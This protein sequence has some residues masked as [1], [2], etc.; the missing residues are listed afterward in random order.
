MR[1]RERDV[2]V[3]IIC[4]RIYD[5]LAL[6]AWTQRKERERERES[7]LPTRMAIFIQIAT[8]PNANMLDFH[9]KIQGVNANTVPEGDS[10]EKGQS[11]KYKIG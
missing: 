9:S 10:T 8:P 3:G 2:D 5:D 11:E 1:E 6:E 7:K 4:V